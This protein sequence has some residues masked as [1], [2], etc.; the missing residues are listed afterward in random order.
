MCNIQ[1]IWD[2]T[3]AE[4]IPEELEDIFIDKAVIT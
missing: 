3:K 1:F 2:Y 4:D